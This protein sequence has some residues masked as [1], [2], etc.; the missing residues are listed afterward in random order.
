MVKGSAYDQTFPASLQLP[1]T[2]WDAAQ[3]LKGST[4]AVDYFGADFVEH[5]AASR[6]WEEREFRKHISQWELERYF[7]I[8]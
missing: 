5:F 4:A 6:E 3:R 8:I 1:A 2:L 7:E